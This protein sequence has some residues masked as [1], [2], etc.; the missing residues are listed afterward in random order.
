MK[1]ILAS[2]AF[3]TLLTSPSVARPQANE[4]LPHSRAYSNP[5]KQLWTTNRSLDEAARISNRPNFSAGPM[6]RDLC[7]TTPSFCPDYHGGNGG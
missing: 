3:A 5:E 4:E 1:V 7:S 6:E 2:L